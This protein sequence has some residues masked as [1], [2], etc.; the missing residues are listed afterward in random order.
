MKRMLRVNPSDAVPIWRQIEEG[1]QRLVASGALARG[2]PVPSV[3]ELAKYL[4]VNPATVA[5][6][7]QKLADSGVLMVKRGEGTFVHETPPPLKKEEKDRILLKG[8]TRYASIAITLGVQREYAV[9]KLESSWLSLSRE[10][11]RS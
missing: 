3:R 4:R 10:G 8:A 11:G 7:Y 2:A 1:V 9:E 6:A 5:K